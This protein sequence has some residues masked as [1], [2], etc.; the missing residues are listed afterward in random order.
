MGIGRETNATPRLIILLVPVLAFL[1]CAKQ[2]NSKVLPRNQDHNQHG[3]G[4]TA[5]ANPTCNVDKVV[6]VMNFGAKADGKHDD[7][8]AFM[9]AW[10]EVCKKSAQPAKLLV[11]EGTYMSSP[12]IFQGPCLS[13]Q[14]VIVEVKGTI[15]ANEDLS[16][17]DEDFWFLFEKINGVILT[18]GGTFDGRGASAWKY[19]DGGSNFPTS[20]KMNDVDNGVVHDLCSVNS[21]FFHFHVTD[22]SNFTA[23]N[24]RITAPCDSPNTDGMHISSTCGVQVS[25][26]VIATG[27]DCISVGPGVTNAN[28]FGITC[29]P[30]HG[31]S[32]GSLGKRDQEKDV[33]GVT[34]SNCTLNNTTNGVRIKTYASPIQIKASDITF[35]DI[36]MN[37]VQNPIVIDQHYGSRKKK[38]GQD[39]HVKISNVHYKNI[40]GTTPSNVPITLACSAAAPCD[41]IEFCDVNLDFVS[42]DLQSKKHP[43]TTFTACCTNAKTTFSGQNK[44]PICE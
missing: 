9:Q 34:F 12:V 24:L 13:S 36:T 38:K 7:V 26:S 17:Y 10:Q 2:C 15:L 11:P 42:D 25:N 44:V 18:G 21:K 22:S 29:G 3:R 23:Y 32:I 20:I 39:S 30:G 1:S 28:I 31:I 19:N 6:D 40:R 4:L 5:D 41:G 37:N 33:C 43:N 8:M 27:D 35:Q 16:A 14:P